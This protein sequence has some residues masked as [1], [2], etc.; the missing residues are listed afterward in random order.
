M[1]YRFTICHAYK[2]MNKGLRVLF[3]FDMLSACLLAPQSIAVG[4]KYV[5]FVKSTR[6]CVHTP[7]LSCNSEE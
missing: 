6:S 1:T 7:S 4:V 2:I 5:L 3:G